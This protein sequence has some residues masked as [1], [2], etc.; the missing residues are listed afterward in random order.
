LLSDSTFIATLKVAAFLPVGGVGQ[1]LMFQ[2][3]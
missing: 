2:G 3:G 1:G